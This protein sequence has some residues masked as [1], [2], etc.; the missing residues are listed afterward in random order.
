M[1]FFGFGVVEFLLVDCVIIVN[2]VFEYGVICGFFLVDV[3]VLVYMCL[4]GRDEK[5][6]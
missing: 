2:M 4:I 5:D 1:E 3:E 6:I